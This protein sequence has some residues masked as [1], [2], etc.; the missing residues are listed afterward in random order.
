MHQLCH[1]RHHEYTLSKF[2]CNILPDT[3]CAI[4][5]GFTEPHNG[6]L[7][8]TQTQTGYDCYTECEPRGYVLSADAVYH[9]VVCSRNGTWLGWFPDD[10]Q[11]SA[12][13]SKPFTNTQFHFVSLNM[14]SRS[15]LWWQILHEI[16][17]LILHNSKIRYFLFVTFFLCNRSRP[18]LFNITGSKSIQIETTNSGSDGFELA[19]EVIVKNCTFQEC[20]RT[21]DLC[22]ESQSV[23]KANVYIRRQ[24]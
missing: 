5:P 24:P 18:I 3:G 14:R 19:T 21:E 8:C 22:R 15:L 17:E 13:R 7:R 11:W 4:P 1:W 6:G 9:Q 20:R 10:Y 23:F 12:C 2:I 16:K